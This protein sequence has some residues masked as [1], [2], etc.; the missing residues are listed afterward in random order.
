MK[1]KSIKTKS[2][3]QL[4]QV[5]FGADATCTMNPDI[6]KIMEATREKG[7][8]PNITV[9]NIT[10]EVADNLA[11]YC[12]AVAV[13]RYSNKDWCY[14]SVKRLTDRGMTQVNIH[15]LLSNETY[16]QVLETIADMKNDPRLEKMNAIVFLSLKPKGRGVKYNSLTMDQFKSVIDFSLESQINFGFDSCSAN[17]FLATVKDSPNFKQYETN[18]EP[19]E[20]SL[21]STYIDV[22]GKFFPC[23]FSPDTD[24]WGSEGIDVANC[25]DF[26][27]DIW[28]N[29]RT[30]EFRKSLLENHRSCPLFKI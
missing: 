3:T 28:Y 18:A 9:A 1:I 11:K 25:E 15:Q 29:E 2:V 16:D 4:T 24:L 5:A 26:M 20:S 8:V 30:N 7:I 12:G 19:C 17:K 23:S 13:S 27:K 6:W 10:D 21:F 14:D 22:Q